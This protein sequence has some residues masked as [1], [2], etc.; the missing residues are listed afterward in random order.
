MF[1][2]FKP[3]PT[4][5]D[6]IDFAKCIVCLAANRILEKIKVDDFEDELLVLINDFIKKFGKE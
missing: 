3:R 6:M 1:N 2:L 5:L 4:K